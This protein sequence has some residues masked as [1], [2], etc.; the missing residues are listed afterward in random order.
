MPPVRGQHRQHECPGEGELTLQVGH[1]GGVQSWGE[2]PKRLE[3]PRK[4]ECDMLGATRFQGLQALVPPHALHKWR[5]P[6]FAGVRLSW[7][8]RTS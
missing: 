5:P 1:S 6:R 4:G 2:D 8:H 3:V 7:S